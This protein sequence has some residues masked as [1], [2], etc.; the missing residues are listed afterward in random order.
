MSAL[1][2]RKRSA[3]ALRERRLWLGLTH[4]QVA[5]LAGM[6]DSSVWRAERSGS[7]KTVER[8]VSALDKYEQ[9]N[10]PNEGVASMGEEQSVVSVVL[11]GTKAAEWLRTFL[12]TTEE[13]YCPVPKELT[14]GLF[15]SAAHDGVAT[16]RKNGHTYWPSVW[17]CRERP[18][19]KETVERAVKKVRAAVEAAR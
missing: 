1:V 11:S 7:V 9:Q 16:I 15:L 18:E 4:Q 3:L 17:L 10:Q 8:I 2:D 13:V 6:S 14:Q 12:V 19:I 5:E